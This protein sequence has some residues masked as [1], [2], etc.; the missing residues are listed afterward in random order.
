MRYVEF[1]FF[2]PLT[3]TLFT[4]NV[5][6]VADNTFISL[7]LKIFNELFDM[8]YPRLCWYAGQQLSNAVAAEDVVQDC[9][10]KLWMRRNTVPLHTLA[11]SYLY[12]AIRHASLNYLRDHKTVEAL[13]GPT[14]P[15]I[16][17][18]P[19]SQMVSTE[20]L[21]AVHEALQSL[22]DK[23]QQV[24]HQLFIE[25]QDTATVAKNLSCT[26]ST[27]RSQKAKGVAILCG[28]LQH[29]LTFLLCLL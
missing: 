17:I 6:L 24:C 19:F 4:F 10:A 12:T 22:P 3:P 2:I 23:C 25:G 18:D 9:F 29:L 21:Q 27:V 13:D 20:T 11:P 28:R 16:G 15:F 26:E 14:L 1:T 8:Y 7:E 5:V